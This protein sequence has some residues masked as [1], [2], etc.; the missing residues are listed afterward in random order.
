M[1][2][3]GNHTAL[4]LFSRS[5]DDEANHKKVV[6]GKA[7]KNR[8]VIDTL[9]NRSKKIAKESKLPL[10]IHTEKEQT[11]NSFGEKI[12]AS[13]SS[14][15]DQ[16][17]ENVII[18]GND[19]LKLSAQHIL[20]AAGEL[21]FNDQVFAP[22]KKGGV[23]I[24]GLKKSTFSFEFKNIRWQ[25]ALTF[26]DL[27]DLAGKNNFSVCHLPL[28]DDINYSNELIHHLKY[29]SAFERFLILLRSIVASS[30]YKL[31]RNVSLVSL[32]FLF[33]YA[34]RGPPVAE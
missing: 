30:S 13:V 5:A 34:F 17:F 6:E 18:I 22:T 25:T 16:G 31:N 26:Q 21:N 23:S 14:I 4:L 1:N 29:S 2:S 33:S 15:I 11:G 12:H 24:I 28:L 32:N 19:C 8:L 3:V 20:A 7:N 9:I 10:F 27:C